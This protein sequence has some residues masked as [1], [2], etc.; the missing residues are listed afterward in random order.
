MKSINELLVHYA[1]L[2]S[3]IRT[4]MCNL[5]SETCGMC[6]ACCCRADI[7]EEAL[8]SAFL[9]RLLKKQGFSDSDM[10][11]RIG[12][13]DLTGCVLEYGKPPICYAYYCDQLLARLPDDETRYVTSVLGKLMYHTGQN[14]LNEW[15]LVEILNQES[16]EK[17]DLDTISKQLNESRAAFEVVEHF[18]QS[19]RLNQS[20]HQILSQIT[21]DSP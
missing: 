4:L 1:E 8:Q 2:E 14:A 17:I 13:L 7:C 20:D 12:W 9:S 18:V 21:T 11:D 15:H 10:D 5:F 6:T 3:S 16:L 19:G